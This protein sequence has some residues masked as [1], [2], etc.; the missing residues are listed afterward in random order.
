MPS[1]SVIMSVYNGA[2][3][4]DDAIKSIVEQKFTDFECIII[5]DCSTDLTEQIIQEW[6]KRDS[7][8]IIFRNE[9]NIGLTKSLNKGISHAQGV[10][11]ARMDADDI[12][13]PLRLSKQYDFMNEHKEMALCGSFGWIIDN[14]GAQVRKKILPIEYKDIK[15]KLLQNNQFIHSSLFIRHDVLKEVG[16]YDEGFKRSQ[17]YELVLRVAAFHI[18]ANISEPLISWRYTKQ[19]LSWQSKGQ[20]WFAL[21]ARWKA[22]NQY[23]YPFFKGAVIII[24]RTFWMLLPGS[25]RRLRYEY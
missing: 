2:E 21:K 14:K 12:A 9:K 17:D 1:V 23:H 24:L 25:L 16:D 7:R 18:V 15:K 8:I 4:L 11:I 19:S 5:D 22:I 3:Y 6:K 10:Y 20:E 13:D